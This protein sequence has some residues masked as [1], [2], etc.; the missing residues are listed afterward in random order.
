LGGGVDNRRP[1]EDGRLRHVGGWGF[2][3]RFD[4][5]SLSRKV[6][7]YLPASRPARRCPM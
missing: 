7:R 6:W 5:T 3:A 2:D 1:K 4:P